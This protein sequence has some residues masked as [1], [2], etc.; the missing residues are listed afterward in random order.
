MEKPYV[1]FYKPY[2]MS[3]EE[4]QYEVEMAQEKLAEWEQE[5]QE[6]IPVELPVMLIFN[7]HFRWYKEDGQYFI[8]H[9]KWSLVGMGENLQ[10]AHRNLLEDISITREHFINIP[11]EELTEEAKKM[12]YWLSVIKVK[13]SA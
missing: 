5:Q 3:D 2:G 12:K 8:E 9:P 7:E 6:S 10:D 4:Y 1:P 13:N 11:D